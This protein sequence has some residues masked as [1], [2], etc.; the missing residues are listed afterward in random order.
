MIAKCKMWLASAAIIGAM[1]HAEGARAEPA[2]IE[3][4][5]S[6]EEVALERN[7][8]FER[9][10]LHGEASSRTRE[11]LRQR[12]WMLSAMWAFT[13]LNYI[14]C[15]LFALM[16][17][18]T[19]QEYE[20]GLVSGLTIDENFL[21]GVV[22]FMQVPLSMVFLSPMLNPRASR[23]ANIAAGAF[24]TAAQTASLFVGRPTK[25]YLVSSVLE[26]SA[27]VFITAYAAIYLKALRVTPT[28]GLGS[29]DASAPTLGASIRF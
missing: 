16:D 6:I 10:P 24:M 26:I 18:R 12:Q 5:N 9:L 28:I 17:P 23:I 29:G 22:F 21:T 20:S 13:S 27:T 2:E 14:Y 7:G 11:R 15:D 1:F 4:A 3:D 19:H 25:Y 8:W